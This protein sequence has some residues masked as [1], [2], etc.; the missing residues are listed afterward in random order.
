MSKL[1][2]NNFEEGLRIDEYL[3]VGGVSRGIT[4][5]GATYLN[6]E[7][8]DNTGTIDAK[9]WDAKEKDIKTVTAGKVIRVNGDILLYRGNLQLRINSAKEVSES[10]Y[11]ISNYVKASPIEEEV[12]KKEIYAYINQIDNKILNQ[13]TSKIIKDNEKDFFSFPAASRIHHEF[14]GGLA[15]HVLGMLKLAENLCDAHNYLSKSLLYSGIILHDV[16]KTIELSGPVLTSYT[17]KGK[18]LGHISIMQANVHDVAKELNIE[19]TEEVTLLRHMILSHHGEYEYGSPVLPMI[20]EAEFLTFIDNI[21]A[22]ANMLDKAMEKTD[23]G[24]FTGRI[25]SL[26]NRSFYKAK[27][28]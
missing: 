7:L 5:A 1:Y 2:V 15:T 27:I 25:F 16:G 9:L 19:E 22:R 3:L 18:L 14:V 17:N 28:K 11:K 8:Q 6:V 24:E 4:N 26:E 23:E 21:D 12:L 10:E 13:I 20:P